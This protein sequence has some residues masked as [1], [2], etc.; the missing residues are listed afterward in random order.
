M[1]S[2]AISVVILA[3]RSGD[4]ARV[5]FSR[6]K[7]VLVRTELDYEIVLVGNYRPGSG[8]TTPDV[9]RAIAEED[10]R[11]NLTQPRVRTVIREKLDPAHAMG[12][13]MRSGLEAATGKTVVVIDGDGQ[14]PP[15]DIPRLYATLVNGGF[16]LCKARRVSRGDGFYRKCISFIFNALMQILFPGIASDINGKPKI[17]TRAAYEVLHL[18]CNDWFIDG[19]IMIKARRHAFKVGEVSTQFLKNPERSSFISLKANFEFLL[20]ILLWRIKEF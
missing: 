2:P 9:V 10:A 17:M 3:Y 11:E 19:E 12:W 6:V 16:D 7:E 5:F 1:N 18:E 4:F 13:D 20:N 15:E 8:D 14:M